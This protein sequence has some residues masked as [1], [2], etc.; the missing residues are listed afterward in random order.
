M[1]VF[2]TNTVERKRCM[3][4][5]SNSFLSRNM[6]VEQTKR[7]G[8]TQMTHIMRKLLNNRRKFEIQR[9]QV[10][11]TSIKISPRLLTTPIDMLCQGPGS[12]SQSTAFNL[13][14]RNEISQSNH[15]YLRHKA[16]KPLEALRRK[17]HLRAFLS[18]AY[19]T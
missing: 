10:L 1:T 19:L 17:V 3:W 2:L 4:M 16:Q 9:G 12:I 14:T 18:E 5:I 6:V 15:S 7:Y 13:K 8:R 11:T